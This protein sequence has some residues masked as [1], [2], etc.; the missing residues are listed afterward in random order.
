MIENLTKD[1]YHIEI[2][3]NEPDKEF[4]L[5]WYG[6]VTD[7]SPDTVL[8][9][10]FN[11]IIEASDSMKHS[12]ILNFTKMD[13]LN[14]STINCIIMLIRKLSAKNVKSK[15]IYSRSIN[16]QALAFSTFEAFLD[17]R[18]LFQISSVK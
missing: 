18:M 12:V 6:K 14:S 1:S 13:Y 5:N 15:L 11:S 16:W 10:Y 17:K 8:T 4:I 2:T 7:R 9:P 3:I